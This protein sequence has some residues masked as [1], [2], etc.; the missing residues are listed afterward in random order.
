MISTME[1]SI[2]QSSKKAPKTSKSKQDLKDEELKHAGHSLEVLYSP[3]NV[4]TQTMCRNMIDR[5]IPYRI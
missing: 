5:G 1:Q 2:Y 3:T 4:P